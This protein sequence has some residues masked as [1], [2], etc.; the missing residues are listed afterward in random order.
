MRFT[1]KFSPIRP[2]CFWMIS[3]PHLLIS[4]FIRFRRG[5]G[6]VFITYSHKF[7]FKFELTCVSQGISP[8]FR[9]AALAPFPPGLRVYGVSKVKQRLQGNLEKRIPA[10]RSRDLRSRGPYSR[11]R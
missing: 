4:M 7:R 1:G 10:P 2:Q 3:I 6:H 11:R 8:A 9:L 5:F